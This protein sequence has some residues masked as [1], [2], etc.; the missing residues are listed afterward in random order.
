MQNTNFWYHCQTLIDY[1]NRRF[2][3]FYDGENTHILNYENKIIE[4]K[5]LFEIASSIRLQFF[6][7]TK[8]E[9]EQIV[10]KYL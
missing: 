7:E 2:P 3:V 10:N 4:N 5:E 1:K 6:D 8:D 9:V